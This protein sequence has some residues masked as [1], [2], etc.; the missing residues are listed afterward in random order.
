MSECVCTVQEGYFFLSLPPMCKKIFIMLIMLSSIGVTGQEI[1]DTI[2][3]SVAVNLPE[4]D[5]LLQLST[6]TLETSVLD[7]LASADTLSVIEQGDPMLKLPKLI[8]GASVVL[9]TDS[10]PKNDMY[11]WKYTVDDGEMYRVPVD[12]LYDRFLVYNPIFKKSISNT[13]LGNFGSPYISNIVSQ[14]DFTEDF[15]FKRAYKA[16]MWTPERYLFFNTK[17]AYTNITYTNGGSNRL[18]EESL[19]VLFSR[20]A[21]RYWNFTGQG[22]VIYGRGLYGEESTKHQNYSF[23]TSF[24]KDKYHLHAIASFNS[25]ENFESGGF[26]ND[27]YVTDPFAVTDQR[28]VDTPEDWPTKLNN[29][30]S[31]LK[32]NYFHLNQKYYLGRYQY[33]DKDS[34]AILYR[35]FAG[36]IHTLHYENSEKGYSEKSFENDATLFYDKFYVD[37]LLTRDK[38]TEKTVSNTLGIYWEEG[39]TNWSEFGL[40]AF[41]GHKYTNYTNHPYQHL[42]ADKIPDTLSH[43]SSDT[44]FNDTWLGGKLYKHEGDNFFFNAMATYYL[45]GRKETD[46]KLNA[47][48]QINLKGN[49]STQLYLYFNHEMKAPDFFTE[50]YY[51]NHFY[52]DNNFNKTFRFDLKAQLD[53]LKFGFRGHAKYTKEIDPVIFNAQ[54]L[55]EQ[56]FDEGINVFELGLRKDFNVGRFVL[57]NEF[58]YQKSDNQNIM[59]VPEYSGYLNWHYRNMLFKVLDLSLGVE[60]RY[61]TAFYAPA[62]MPA[63]GQ[64]YLQNEV[65]IGGYPLV[66]PYVQF[67][68]KRMRVFVKMYHANKGLGE[69]NYFS[70]PHYAYNPRFIKF[71]LSWNFYN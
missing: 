47:D 43:F 14:R 50:H 45:S 63:T 55:P 71:G 64:F 38:A 36:I 20:N 39:A 46:Y 5:S 33:T 60:C 44:V 68:L 19:S 11:A 58:I 26:T 31:S 25:L 8:V 59:P 35:P 65:E 67:H 62:Y 12:T 56:M 17:E 70:A 16:Y 22:E 27:L 32:S 54:A 66:N 10:F 69:L 48:M 1:Q 7:S 13:Y 53:L 21:G 37:S 3:D 49:D 4:T 2:V 6:D 15:I 51:S 42:S 9:R 24:I 34:S 61:N 30:T 28:G 41:V 57:E 29:V 18:G 23:L 40:G 52:W